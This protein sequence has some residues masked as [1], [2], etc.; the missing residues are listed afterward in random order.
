MDFNKQDDNNQN[1]A[2]NAVEVNDDC[3]TLSQRSEQVNN[4]A[5]EDDQDSFSYNKLENTDQIMNR[6]ST[7]EGAKS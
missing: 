5:M 2:K 1:T 6:P 7:G 3:D 4:E